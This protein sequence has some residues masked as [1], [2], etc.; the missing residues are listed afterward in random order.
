LQEHHQAEQQ[1]LLEK[2]YEEHLA[3]MELHEEAH[4]Y[5]RSR[6]T[7]FKHSMQHPLMLLLSCTM[8]RVSGATVETRAMCSRCGEY[9]KH[10]MRGMHRTGVFAAA[11]CRMAAGCGT[12]MLADAAA[13]LAVHGARKQQQW[14]LAVLLYHANT[15]Q[16]SAHSHVAKCVLLVLM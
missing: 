6:A 8:P 10:N 1:E 2:Q 15:R 13:S 14:C 7:A 16:R 3:L 9:G 12:A 11:A 4:S 5:R